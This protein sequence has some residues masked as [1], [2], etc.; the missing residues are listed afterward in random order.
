MRLLLYFVCTVSLLYLD[1]IQLHTTFHTF[2]HVLLDW[3][4]SKGKEHGNMASL[5]SSAE[6]DKRLDSIAAQLSASI[7]DAE[8]LVR[9]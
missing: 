4:A 7:D 6:L 5:V 2:A 9:S 3:I 8:G 1:L